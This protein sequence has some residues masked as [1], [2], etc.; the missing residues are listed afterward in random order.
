MAQAMRPKQF[1]RKNKDI[2]LTL[3]ISQEQHEQYWAASV[4]DARTLSDWI[5]I[6]L[7]RA[8]DSMVAARK[9][10]VGFLDE[11]E[12]RSKAAE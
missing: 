6:T 7:D 3:R 12:R 8:A 1:K 5:R 10:A 4:G 2:Q 9:R 11:A